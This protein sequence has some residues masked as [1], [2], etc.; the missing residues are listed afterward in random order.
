[1]L[2]HRPPAIRHAIP[3]ILWV[4]TFES[5]LMIHCGVKGASGFETGDQLAYT[6]SLLPADAV[7]EDVP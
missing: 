4:K 2:L 1:M 5:E 6:D 7:H 3:V